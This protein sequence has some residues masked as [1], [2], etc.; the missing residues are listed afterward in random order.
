MF[1]N[2]Q[3]VCVSGVLLYLHAS[4]A[5]EAVKLCL[6]TD[7]PLGH[8]ISHCIHGSVLCNFKRLIQLLLIEYHLI[9]YLQ[10]GYIYSR[11]RYLEFF[12]V[13]EQ[14]HISMQ[15]V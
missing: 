13:S 11:H 3:A 4:D 10:I 12:D 15:Y 5:V 2:P 7:G 9:C 8:P 1:C 14:D 6:H